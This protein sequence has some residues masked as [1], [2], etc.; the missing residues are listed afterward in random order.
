PL[1]TTIRYDLTGRTE[2]ARERFEDSHVID[3]VVAYG[4]AW[5]EGQLFGWLNQL[6][7]LAT[8]AMLALM[9]IS[10]FVMWRRRKP[11]GQLGAPHPPKAT[12]RV[13]GVAVIV[14]ALATLLPLLAISL[15]AVVLIERLVL[16]RIPPISR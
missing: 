10:G 15:A 8:A 1:R 9:A 3:R 5:H 14:L 4:V 13:R 12:A 16:V 2:L 11:A 6:I 7:G